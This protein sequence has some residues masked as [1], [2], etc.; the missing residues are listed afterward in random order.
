VRDHYPL[1]VPEGTVP[2][3][4]RLGMYHVLGNGQFENTEWVSISVPPK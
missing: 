2:R 3:S 1:Q 4:V